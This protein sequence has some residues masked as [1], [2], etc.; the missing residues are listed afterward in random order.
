MKKTA[1]VILSFALSIFLFSG[2]TAIGEKSASFS[3]VYGMIAVFSLILLSGYCFLLNKKENWFIV[4]FSSVFI[5]NIGYFCLSISENLEEALLANRISYLGSV[6]LPMSMFVTIMNV[7]KINYKKWMIAVL[8]TISF[9]VFLVAASPGY[10]DIYYKSVSFVKIN[11]VSVLEKVYGPWHNIYFFYLLLYFGSMV[12]IIVYAS[13]EKKIKNSV[14]AVLLASSVFVNISVWLFEQLVKLDFEF[15]SVSYIISEIFL[16]GISLLLQEKEEDYKNSLKI[17]EPVYEVPENPS[18]LLKETVTV[19]ETVSAKNDFTAFEKALSSLTPTERNIY[20]FH[21]SGKKTK[22]IMEELCI[23]ENTVKFHN[24][25]IY[26][27]F[28]VSSKK[29]LLE[30]CRENGIMA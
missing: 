30:L 8:G 7:C 14:H 4:L 27:K 26:R 9:F 5:V 2:C 3:V 21:L 6:F 22:E 16:L 13:V 19:E 17:D 28:G 29:E 1:S 20:N 24:K 10:L 25:N 18:F 15:L 12:G 11:G 23:T